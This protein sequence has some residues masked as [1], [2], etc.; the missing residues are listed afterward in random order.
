MNYWSQVYKVINESDIILEVLDARFVE[1]TRNK[2][3]EQKIKNSNKKII[4]VINKVDLVN[5]D[6]IKKYKHPLKPSF[7]IS[8]INRLGTTLLKKQILTYANEITRK[9]KRNSNNLNANNT[10]N[11]N[12]ISRIQNKNDKR[13]KR[14]ENKNKNNKN[15]SDN[16]YNRNHSNLNQRDYRF[17][18][19]NDRIISVGV[20]GY[21]NTGKSSVI[22]SIAGRSKAGVSPISGYTKHTQKIKLKKGIFLNDTPGVIP[23]DSNDEIKLALFGAIDQTKIKN[24]DAFIQYLFNNY[25]KTIESHFKLEKYEKL[26]YEEKLNQ[27]AFKLNFLEKNG[28]PDINRTYNY[29]IKQWQQGKIKI[30]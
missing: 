5:R 4:Y 26:S 1:L 11:A 15:R 20:I 12:D 23:F 29:I 22:N 30:I 18:N 24:K 6:V 27:I 3:I 25:S 16:A 28:L 9:S 17:P 2:K 7:Y 14:N 21:P 19:N 13:N 8:S 10:T